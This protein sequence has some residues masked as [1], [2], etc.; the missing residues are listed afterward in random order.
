MGNQLENADTVGAPENTVVYGEAK[1]RRPQYGRLGRRGASG[2]TDAYKK[3][4]Q[5]E[6][7]TRGFIP[8]L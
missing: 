2:E 7:E 3:I 6:C 8:R 1:I 4:S 5:H